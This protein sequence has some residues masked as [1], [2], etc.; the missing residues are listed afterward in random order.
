MRALRVRWR[1]HRHRGAGA[2]IR[3]GQRIGASRSRAGVF[4]LFNIKCSLHVT[5]TVIVSPFF[6]SRSQSCLSH[7]LRA[8]AIG[9]SG[10]ALETLV[11]LLRYFYP[12]THSD[13]FFLSMRRGG[14]S[15]M[16]CL[17]FLSMLL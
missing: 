8:A 16:V 11:Q 2:A 9:G 15:L 5:I 10:D 7:V 14:G 17:R 1:A 3:P 4:S 12:R 6:Y 13:S